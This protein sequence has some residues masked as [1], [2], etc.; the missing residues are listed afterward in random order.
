LCHSID[1]SPLS[2]ERGYPLRLIDFGL[3]GYKSV[4]ALAKLEVTTAYELGEWEERAGYPLDGTVRP[5][6]YWICD[7]RRSMF[8]PAAGEITDF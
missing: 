7:L 6:K 5:K 8:A 3:Y 2:L 4:K 1:G